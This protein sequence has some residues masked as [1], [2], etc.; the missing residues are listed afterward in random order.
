MQQLEFLKKKK[1]FKKVRQLN[2]FEENKVFQKGAVIKM[3]QP[4]VYILTL[5]STII[6]GGIFLGD[7][8]KGF[9]K[10]CKGRHVSALPH[11][12]CCT[13][14]FSICEMHCSDIPARCD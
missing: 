8:G 5:A 13:S 11:L 4:C 1:Y 7:F 12:H 3:N 14:S 6:Q 10:G 9:L 2:F